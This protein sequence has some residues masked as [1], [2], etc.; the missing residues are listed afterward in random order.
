MNSA[1]RTVTGARG[2]KQQVQGQSERWEQKLLVAGEIEQR[3][4]KCRCKSR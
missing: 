2:T 3:H 1:E 4:E